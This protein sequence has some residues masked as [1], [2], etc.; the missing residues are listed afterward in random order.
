MKLLVFP[1]INSL[2]WF[3][4]AR[5]QV[6]IFTLSF[7]CVKIGHKQAQA[8]MGELYARIAC[9]RLTRANCHTLA[10]RAAAR[11]AGR[12]AGCALAN[13]PA[14]LPAI[15]CR[16]TRAQL[17]RAR[18]RLARYI[19]P[20]SWPFVITVQSSLAGHQASHLTLSPAPPSL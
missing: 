20:R 10:L 15:A 13:S 9:G 14:S 7:L 2:G 16:R 3:D 6:Y 11:P 1:N 12:L 5:T 18:A 19:R 17:E 8:S 4:I